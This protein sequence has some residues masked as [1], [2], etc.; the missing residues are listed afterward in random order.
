M[1]A[2]AKRY[3]GVHFW[4][5][6]MEPTK[7]QNFQPLSADRG[8][9][10]TR[11]VGRGAR[12]YARMLDSAYGALKRVNRRN[13]VIGG[14]TFTTGTVSPRNWIRAMRLPGGKR[15]RM[16][17]YGHNPFTVRPP[18]KHNAPLGRGWADIYDLRVLHGWLH[19]YF[20]HHTPRVFVSEFVLPTD[21]ENWQFN[22]FLSQRQQVRWLR[23]ALRIAR[24]DK[25]LFSFG[26][27]GLFDEAAR[28][29][30]RQVRWGLL[31]PDGTPKPAFDVF[32]RG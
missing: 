28:P 16:D 7:S 27:L 20:R 21:H 15:P 1:S 13:Q 12:I 26:Y 30:G 24:R 29:D 6:W 2:A 14:N 4:M 25:R 11:S 19:R 8:G 31:N 23:A 22:F 9:R 10:L 5:A 3:P 18:R 32:R 17:L